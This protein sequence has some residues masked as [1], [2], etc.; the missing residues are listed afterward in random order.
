MDLKK[1]WKDYSLSIVLGTLFIL[2]WIGQSIFQWLEFAQDEN[3]HGQAANLV[4]FL[5]AFL[6]ATFEN[7][8]SEFLQLFSMIVLTSFLVH[9]GAPESKDS[10]E[11]TEA[12]LSRIEKRLDKLEF[13]KV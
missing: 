13:G 11:K 12:A 7:W 1:L 8:Q 9:K 10:E 3:A 2:S 6:S 5:P 4:N